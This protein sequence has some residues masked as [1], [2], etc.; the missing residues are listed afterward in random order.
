MKSTIV[1]Q[2]QNEAILMQHNQTLFQENYVRSQNEQIL[3]TEWKKM[4]QEKINAINEVHNLQVQLNQVMIMNEGLQKKFAELE[5]RLPK[6]DETISESVTYQIDEE[7]LA[8]ETEWIRAKNRKKRKMD[9]SLTPPQ[10]SQNV[11]TPIEKTKKEQTPPPIIIDNIKDFNE[12]HQVIGKTVNRFQIKIISD[13]N[14]KVNVDNIEDYRTLSKQLNE[15]NYSWHS[16]ENKQNRP[17]KV[18]VNKLHHTIKPETIVEDLR[19]RGYK[20][21]DAIPKRSYRTKKPINMFMLVFKHDENVDKIYGI[22]DIQGIRVEILPLRKTRLVPQCKRCQAYGHTK[23]YCAKEPRCV[24]C[25]GKHLTNECPQPKNVQPKCVH[26]G[27]GHPANY[28]GC[29]VA[30]EM[31]K[32]KDKNTKKVIRPNQPQRDN[33]RN[34]APAT[35]KSQ[36]RTTTNN[37]E[38]R[39]TYNMAVKNTTEDNKKQNNPA[40]DQILQ[41]ILDKLNKLDDRITRLEYSNKGAIPKR[42][43]NERQP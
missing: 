14:V 34:P 25:V 2:T 29:V 27:E 37:A 22:T 43:G 10:R 32:L 3:Y 1:P 33:N 13:S 28:R 18:I 17:I 23:A 38:N 5:K 24:R 6:E 19:H 35:E 9:T 21:L 40:T 41:Q 12:C 7:E 4:E 11:P 42:L 26:C 36:S 39:K 20:L 30:K 8:K 15:C 16:Y 31:Q